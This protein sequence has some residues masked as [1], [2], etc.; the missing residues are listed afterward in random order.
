MQGILGLICAA[1]GGWAAW[2]AFNEAEAGDD[3]Y[4]LVGLVAVIVCI[5]GILLIFMR[6][7]KW[8]EAE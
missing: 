3:S 4:T 1:G 2:W 5:I 7:K 6:I 8:W